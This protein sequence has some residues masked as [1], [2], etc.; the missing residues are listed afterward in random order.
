[1]KFSVDE[2]DRQGRQYGL[3]MASRESRLKAEKKGSN[4]DNEEPGRR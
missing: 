1:V 3:L 4:I 2:K